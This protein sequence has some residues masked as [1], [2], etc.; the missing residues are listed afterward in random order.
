MNVRRATPDDMPA[1]LRMGRSFH[2]TT[3][4]ADVAYDPDSIRFIC[5]QLMESGVLLVA[6]IKGAAVG[7][8]GA[9]MAPLFMNRDALICSEVFWW[10][11]PEAR[12]SGAGKEMA[13]QLETICREAGVYR[14]AMVAIHAPGIEQVESMYQRLGFEPT[15]NTWTKVLWQQQQQ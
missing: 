7:V 4:Y 10:V 11:D 13:K 3:P 8:V 15:E 5:T 9:V 2:E 14:L 6:E 12:G 1:L